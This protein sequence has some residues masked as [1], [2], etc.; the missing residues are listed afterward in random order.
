MAVWMFS[1]YRKKKKYILMLWVIFNSL[2][3][4]GKID[5]SQIIINKPITYKNRVINLTNQSYF[6]TNNAILDIENSIIKGTI[7]PNNPILF[8]LS[9]GKIIFKNNKIFITT[10]NIEPDPVNLTPFHIFMIDEGKIELFSNDF[11]IDKPYVV[12]VLMTGEKP[13]SDFII[14]E[15]HFKRFHGGLF[16]YNTKNLYIQNNSFTVVSSANIFINS[17][18]DIQVKKNNMLF[19][20]GN[21]VGDAIDVLDSDNI[22]ISKNY[23]GSGSCYGILIF[24]CKNVRINLNTIVGDIT[25]GIDVVSSFSSSKNSKY[26]SL[27]YNRYSQK[28]NDIGNFN[29]SI[30]HNFL[31]QNRFGLVVDN[32]IGLEISNNYFIQHFSKASDRQFWTDNTI[33]ITHTPEMSWFNNF[34]KEAYTQVNGGDNSQSKQIV[35]FP[36][37]NGVILP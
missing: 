30:T 22:T 5:A 4:F 29:I 21:N 15:N 3:C 23:I 33:L 11:T 19:S 18:V 35:L 7:S 13:T 14:N 6:I 10:N 8:Y 37:Y 26:L 2:F 1:K 25:Y 36:K 32:A 31:S 9:S 28:K 34:Y 27:L 24:N 17:S 12:N 20:G 16:I